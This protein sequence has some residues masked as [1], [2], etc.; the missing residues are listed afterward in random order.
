M[1]IKSISVARCNKMLHL[2]AVSYIFRSR[3]CYGDNA[4]CWIKHCGHKGRHRQL[5]PDHCQMMDEKLKIEPAP[6]SQIFH[7]TAKTQRRKYIISNYL[8]FCAL[9]TWR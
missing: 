9:A 5:A 8:K 4:L 7:F 2:V 6:K 3:A 1:Q